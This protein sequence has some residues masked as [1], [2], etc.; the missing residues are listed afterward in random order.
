MKRL[1]C[2]S[3]LAASALLIGPWGAAHGVDVDVHIA[4]PPPPHIVFEAEPQIVI[5]PQTHVHYVPAVTD[6]DMYRYGKYW[7]VNQDGY[8]YR[9][10][11]F[12]GPFKF[13]SH[14]HLPR[15]VVVVPAEYRHHPTHPRKAHK[16]KYKHKHK[17]DRHDDDD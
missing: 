11:S 10:R 1:I 3:A 13:V 4:I 12:K 8:W 2:G 9:S 16:Y 7:Y 6:Y 14:R 17:H 5:V 15:E